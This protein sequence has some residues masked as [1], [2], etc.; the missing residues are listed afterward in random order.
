MHLYPG[1]LWSYNMIFRQITHVL[2]QRKWNQLFHRTNSKEICKRAYKMSMGVF[3]R[4]L[5][6]NVYISTAFNFGKM[7]QEI[8]YMVGIQWMQSVPLD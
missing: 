2:T 8:Q 4:S 7:Q 3:E 5:K 1:P 6:A